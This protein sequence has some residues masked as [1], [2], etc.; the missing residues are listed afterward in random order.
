[1]KQ[2]I[3]KHLADFLAIVALFLLAV[4]VGA[5][6]LHN[7]RLRFPLIEAKPTTVKVELPDA[8]AVQPGQGQTVRVAGVEIGDSQDRIS[9][10]IE[11]GREELLDLGLRNPLLNYRPSRARGVELI[12][13]LPTVAQLSTSTQP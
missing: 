6:I 2:A 10:I 4:G 13:E 5:Y 8:Q 11:A 3:R 9:F 7:E 1:M 12:D